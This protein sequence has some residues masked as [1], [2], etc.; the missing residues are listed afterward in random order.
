MSEII[1]QE[2]Y[3]NFINEIKTQIQNSQIKAAISVNSEMLKLYWNLA[4]MIVEK[5]EKSSWGEG[6]LQSISKD[7]K[8]EFPTMK[9]FTAR[10]LQYMKQWYKYWF[11]ITPQVVAQ[12]SPQAVGFSESK[13]IVQIPWGHNREIITK[14]KEISEAIFYVNKTIENNWSRDVLTNQISFGL[15]KKQGMAVTNFKEKLPDYNSDLAIQTLKDP[16]CFDFLTL[17]DNYNEKE[18]LKFRY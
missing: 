3:K 2:D 17:T 10:N 16:Y 9:G 15:Y 12:I 4:E 6:I 11:Q 7:L 8:K 14:C 5:Q 1:N 13:K 18:V